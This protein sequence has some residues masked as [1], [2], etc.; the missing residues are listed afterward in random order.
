MHPDAAA[1]V[2]W[3]ETSGT[4][5]KPCGFRGPQG[6]R[7]PSE[8]QLT[9]WPASTILATTLLN[10]GD[11]KARGGNEVRGQIQPTHPHILPPRAR[12]KSGHFNHVRLLS[13]SPDPGATPHPVLLIY[14]NYRQRQAISQGFR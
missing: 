14:T 8:F 9:L 6:S 12:V 3:C 2:N 13:T 11:R 5:K 7:N 4:T 1:A 10:H